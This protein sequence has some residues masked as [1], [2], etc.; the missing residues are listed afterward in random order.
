MLFNIEVK[1]MKNAKILLLV[2]SC[3]ITSCANF[4]LENIKSKDDK[5]VTYEVGKVM[6]TSIGTEMISIN[7]KFTLPKFR[8]R[9]SYQPPAAELQNLPLIEP[10][11]EWVA[12][13][14]HDDLFILTSS[15]YSQIVGVEIDKSGKI[16]DKKPWINLAPHIIREG[17]IT[18][19]LLFQRTWDL[20]DP[21]LFRPD[22]SYINKGSYRIDLIYGGMVNN[23][24]EILSKEY[25]D[26]FTKAARYQSTKY[27]LS[28]S[29]IISYKTIKMQIMEATNSKI[30]FK[31]LED[32]G[33]PWVFEKGI[34]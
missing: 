5:T 19:R 26:D 8:P 6:S 17:N 32:G 9:Y 2:V 15:E 3:L 21:Q 23:V 20:P 16:V 13:Y 30:T 28:S 34:Q 33:L 25:I 18:A 10:T 1:L 7:N 29:D 12:F 14:A 27:N 4:K 31:V 22:G 11:Q 24:I